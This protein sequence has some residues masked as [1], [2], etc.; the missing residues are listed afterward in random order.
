[1]PRSIHSLA[2]A[3]A[4]VAGP[5]ASAQITDLTQ[6]TV[7]EDP[8]DPNLTATTTPTTATLQATAP[9]PNAADIG[10]ATVNANTVAESTEGFAFESSSSFSLA[11]DFALDWAGADGG[12]AVGFGIGEDAAGVNSA[13]AVFAAGTA[14][15]F[16]FSTAGA[17]ATNNDTP[18]GLTDFGFVVS[19]SNN[20]S[21]DGRLFV[22]YNASNR[23]ITV[24]FSDAPG[25]DTPD[26]TSLILGSTLDQSSGDDLL[27]SF[28]IRSQ[29]FTQQIPGGFGPIDLTIDPWTAGNAT[30]TFSNFEILA[31][32]ANAIPE[33]TTAIGLGLGMLCL[34]SRRRRA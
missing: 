18:V 30:A 17:A 11:I 21:A 16:G 23:D 15:N 14:G 6:W 13:G 9:V 26:S 24:G 25:A 27:A 8:P 19:S 7:I 32:S 12:I 4:L 2:A 29:S 34:I 31:G 33:P 22:A 28:F 3:L 5:F 1:M 20:G 10:Y